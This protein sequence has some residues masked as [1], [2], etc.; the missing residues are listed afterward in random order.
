MSMTLSE[1]TPK[2]LTAKTCVVKFEVGEGQRRRREQVI[3]IGDCEIPMSDFCFLVEYV[4]TNT[5]LDDGDP[6]IGMVERIRRA[7]VV[8]GHN[9]EAGIYPNCLRYSM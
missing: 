5:D 4:L 2:D 7:K 6:R 1:S 3:M 8:P 9:A